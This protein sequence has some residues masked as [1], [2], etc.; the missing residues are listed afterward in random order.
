M[1]IVNLDLQKF[2]A[3]YFMQ[4]VTYNVYMMCTFKRHNMHTYYVTSCTMYIH[5]TLIIF[6]DITSTDNVLVSFPTKKENC[7]FSVRDNGELWKF[8]KEDGGKWRRVKEWSH[9]EVS[10]SEN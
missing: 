1:T 2:E 7:S 6:L 9:D 8:Q 3:Q 10:Q 4:H 5:D